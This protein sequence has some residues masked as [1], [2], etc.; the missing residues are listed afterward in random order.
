MGIYSDPKLV[1]LMYDERVRE[2]HDSYAQAPLVRVRLTPVI[3]GLARLGDGV[4]RALHAAAS[5]VASFLV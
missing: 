2:L 3:K 5:A 1:K 4:G